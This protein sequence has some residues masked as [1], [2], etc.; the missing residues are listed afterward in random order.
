MF[1]VFHERASGNIERINAAT[2]THH[3]VAGKVNAL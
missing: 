2:F 1:E 3:V